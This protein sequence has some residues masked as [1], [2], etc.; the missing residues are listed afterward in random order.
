MSAPRTMN[1]QLGRPVEI[2]LVEDSPSDADLTMDMLISGRIS[3]HVS[4]VEDGVEAIAFLRQQGAYRDAQRPD[5]ILLDLNLPRKNGREVLVEIK[6]DPGLR[7]IPVVVLTSSRAEQDLLHAHQHH[8]S[9]Y[10]AKPVGFE[11]FLEV[12]RNIEGFWLSVVR[13]PGKD[14][15]VS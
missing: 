9:S 6:Q 11:Q 14:R 5:L 13:I 4:V 12:L 15:D 10:V 3:N 8:A 1:T 7:D 2:L